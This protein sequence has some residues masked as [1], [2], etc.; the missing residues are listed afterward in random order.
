M[1]DVRLTGPIF[2][3]RAELYTRAMIDEVRDRV[4][5]AAMDA[6]QSAL[7]HT[8]RVDRGRY[9]SQLNI[10]TRGRDLVL[11]DHRSVYGPW[12]EGT[13]SRNSP[14]TRF[15]GYHN[16]RLVTGQIKS[17]V[18]GLARPVVEKWVRRLN[19]A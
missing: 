6:W 16:A 3:V 17:Q 13:G 8:I 18:D 10:A 19:D 4:A 14:V 11:N 7:E 15:P 12:L 1:A 9:R 2:D 5:D